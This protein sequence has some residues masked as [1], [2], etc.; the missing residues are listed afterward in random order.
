[1]LQLLYCDSESQE[2]GSSCGEYDVISVMPI[3]K[4]INFV[5]WVVT[6][7]NLKKLSSGLTFDV[8]PK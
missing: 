4:K 7:N 3:K 8:N 1:M 2:F 6:V 5:S